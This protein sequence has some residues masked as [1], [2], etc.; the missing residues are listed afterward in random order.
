MTPGPRPSA[1][2]QRAEARVS[3]LIAVR[4]VV[5]RSADRPHATLRLGKGA[6]PVA[7]RPG[8]HPAPGRTERRGQRGQS[9]VRA[10]V[11]VLSSDLS[12]AASAPLHRGETAPWRDSVLRWCDQSRQRR[13]VEGLLSLGPPPASQPSPSAQDGFKICGRVDIIY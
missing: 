1:S 4:G 5:K 10:G 2:C 6:G 9:R 3:R 11:P 8:A 12:P 13:T 7:G